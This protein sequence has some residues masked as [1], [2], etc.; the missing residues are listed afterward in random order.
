MSAPTLLRQVLGATAIA[1]EKNFSLFRKRKD[2][3]FYGAAYLLK[4]KVLMRRSLCLFSAPYSDMVRMLFGWASDKPGKSQHWQQ[5]RSA[6]C[7]FV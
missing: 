3:K 4:G 2:E 5:M 7:H 6:H 1:K